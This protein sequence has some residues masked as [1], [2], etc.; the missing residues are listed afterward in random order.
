M[1]TSGTN[2][3]FEYVLHGKF[4]SRLRLRD[5]SVI[6]NLDDACGSLI[7]QCVKTLYPW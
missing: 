4:A 3:G 7:W 5:S 2:H 6:A 1:R